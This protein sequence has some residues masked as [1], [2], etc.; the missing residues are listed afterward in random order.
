MNGRVDGSL[1]IQPLYYL[2]MPKGRQTPPITMLAHERIEQGKTAVDIAHALGVANAW[3]GFVERGEKPERN[4]QRRERWAEL[5]G[6]PTSDLFDN[7]DRS[8]AKS[9]PG[10]RQ[11]VRPRVFALPTPALEARVVRLDQAGKTRY[12][13][14][15]ATNLAVS[16]VDAIRRERGLTNPRAARGKTAGRER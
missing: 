9:L 12:Q 11:V 16:T 1:M 13:I 6:R 8:Y 14:M 4:V 3:V 5:L 10:A 15:R 2:L 7:D